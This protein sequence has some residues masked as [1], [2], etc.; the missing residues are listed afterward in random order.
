MYIGFVEPASDI[1]RS[2]PDRTYLQMRKSLLKE[3]VELEIELDRISGL[4]LL[5]EQQKILDLVSNYQPLPYSISEYGCGMKCDI[6]IRKLVELGLP[7]YAISRGMIMEKDMSE[8]ALATKDHQARPHSLTLENRMFHRIN[9][10]N[11][12]QMTLL[13]EAGII[14]DPTL[15]QIRTGHF[16]ISHQKTI[17]FVN[18]RSHIFTFVQFWDPQ[19][20][21]NSQ[22]II[23]LTTDRNE[24]FTVPQL[25]RYLHASES[26]L[27]EAPLLGRFLIRPDHLTPLQ[28]KSYTRYFQ[29]GPGAEMKTDSTL[30]TILN[31]A[32]KGSIGD[33]STWTYANNLPSEDQSVYQIQ[34]SRT[35]HGDS[36]GHLIAD[37]I[38]ARSE[39]QDEKVVEVLQQLSSI[40]RTT[41]LATII[42][43]DAIRAE[44]ALEPLKNLVDVISTSISLQEL[45]E[46]LM[47]GEDLSAGISDV[48]ELNLLFGFS[49]RLRERIQRLARISKN[50]EGQIDACALNPHFNEA[51]IDCIQQMNRAGLKV[52][53]DQ[54]GNLHGL[55]IDQETFETSKSDMS[56]LRQI[57]RHSICICSHIDTVKDGGKYD[58]RLGVLS[59]I[60]VAE[61]L[62]DLDRFYHLD[63]TYPHTQRCCMVSAF[64]GEEMTFTGNH[65]SMPGSAAVTGLASIA[66]IYGMRNNEGQLFEEELN[67]LLVLLGDAKAGGRIDIANALVLDGDQRSIDLPYEP[68][69]FFSPNTYERHIEQGIKLVDL[70][71]P[72]TQ[73]EIIMGIHQEDFTF[74]GDH[75]EEAALRFNMEIRHLVLQSRFKGLRITVGTF[76]YSSDDCSELA[77]DYGMRWTLTGQRD[78]AGGTEIADR[79]DAGVALARLKDFVYE[80][81]QEYQ[82][83]HDKKIHLTAGGIEFTPGINRNVIPGTASISFG[84]KGDSLVESDRFF[85]QQQI[86]AYIVGTLYLPVNQGGE[87]ILDFTFQEISHVNK[88]HQVTCSIDLRSHDKSLTLSFLGTLTRTLNKISKGYNVQTTRSIEQQLDPYQLRDTGQVLQLERSFGG[89]HNPNETQLTQDVL[90]GLILQFAVTY[91]FLS[92]KSSQS[93]NLFDFVYTRIPNTWKEKLPRFI[94]GALHDTCNISRKIRTVQSEVENEVN[95]PF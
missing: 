68:T 52:F 76:Q 39:N 42:R 58:G 6:T 88:S 28:L 75:S 44:N 11:H 74:T 49:F 79:R 65:V 23:D 3:K 51:V 20:N 50:E 29:S 91:D 45:S 95:E 93:I 24:F 41:G 67:Q 34:L 4:P 92:L 80:L 73:V 64:I 25:R 61:M 71:I 9:F 12:I 13:K 62:H 72:L 89:S 10:Q 87:G 16:N 53:V 57:T 47:E 19:N 70:K 26:L 37:L 31:K 94:S 90:R 48:R 35:G 63:T 81:C 27:L 83:T 40:E 30:I 5:G 59:G 85:I 43:E 33:P 21:T 56:Y 7:M 1:S 2:D 46:R 60:E 77:F 8:E 54:V 55:L 18:A 69:H 78:H 86:K 38:E 36:I 66:D 22:L 17:Q 82:T 14:V 32:E 84:I 15:E